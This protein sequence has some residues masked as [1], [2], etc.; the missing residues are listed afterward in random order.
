MRKLVAVK[1]DASLFALLKALS[2]GAHIC[3]VLSSKTSELVTIVSQGSAF[4]CM[5]KYFKEVSDDYDKITLGNFTYHT[6][7][8]WQLQNYFFYSKQNHY[9]GNM[10]RLN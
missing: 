6:Y 3:A 4:R 7:D 2:Q 9:L 8:K 10:L 5:Y 1:E